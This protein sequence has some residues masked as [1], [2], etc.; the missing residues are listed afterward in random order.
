[1]TIHTNLAYGKYSPHISIVA[2]GSICPTGHLPMRIPIFPGDQAYRLTS[3][4]DDW[5]ALE[6]TLLSLAVLFRCLSLD[7][8]FACHFVKVDRGG[9]SA[10]FCKH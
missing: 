7:L 8:P 6:A 5:C 1:M 3:L 2:L 10:Y 4:G 9:S